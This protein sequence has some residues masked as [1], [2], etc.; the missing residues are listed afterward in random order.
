MN[1]TQEKEIKEKWI[2]KSPSNGLYWQKYDGGFYK[3]IC[4]AFDSNDATKKFVIYQEVFGHSRI[5]SILQEEFHGSINF[6]DKI[7]KRFTEVSEEIALM[8]IL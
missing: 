4:V 8:S 3:K 2:T 6:H 1:F 5:F 7:I